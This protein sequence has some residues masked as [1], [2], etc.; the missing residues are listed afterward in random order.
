[1]K[2]VFSVLL[3]LLA[4][5]SSR[6]QTT[7]SDILLVGTFHFNN[8]GADLTKIK[9]FDVLSS[10]SQAELENITQ[11]ISVFHP[12]KIF[13][14]WKW[15]EQKELDGLYAAYLAG[16][17]EQYVAATFPKPATRN[18]Y[19][20]NEI[21]QLAFR[22]GKKGRLNKIYALDYSTSFPYDSVMKAMRAAN[23]LA[24]I[25]KTQAAVKDMED[26]TNKKME[27]YSLTQLLLDYNTKESLAEN[28]ALYFEIFNRAGAADNFV[29]PFLVSEW[30]RRNLYMYSI[31]Q[32]N[33]APEDGKA[34]IL[35]G[36]GH[37]AMMKE[38]IES[39]K[40]FRLKELKD[41]LK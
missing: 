34:L 10:K 19:L 7:P 17:Y 15:N 29:G 5:T 40:Q 14:E 13:V 1:M 18:F 24:L 8:P 23:Q 37:A 12:A 32:K 26:R 16:N 6:A 36:A 28:K 30:Y 9:N 25:Q 38:F 27:T 31:V 39:D 4:F 3:C 2:V 33:M 22:A 21:V 11:K 20:K 35:V 41:I